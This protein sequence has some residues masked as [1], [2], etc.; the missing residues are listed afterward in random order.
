MANTF[1]K[2]LQ[3]KLIPRFMMGVMTNM[4]TR[5]LE[6]GISLDEF[7]TQQF[8]IISVVIGAMTGKIVGGLGSEK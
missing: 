6:W 1:E 2:I 4:Y 7:S 8:A 3:Y 5:G